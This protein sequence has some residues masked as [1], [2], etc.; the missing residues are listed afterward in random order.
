MTYLASRHQEFVAEATTLL[1]REIKITYRYRTATNGMAID[2][3]ESEAVLLS[4]SPLI[5]SIVPDYQLQIETYA[6]PPW[7]GAE[8]IWYGDA[9]IQARG[10][11]V[12]VGVI[13]TGINWDHPSFEDPAG[14]GYKH[15]NPF[16][17]YLGL[18][19]L[20][21]VNCN[22]KLVGVYDFVTD[23]PATE[24]V[25]EENT[26]GKDNHNHGSHTASTAAGNPV[27]VFVNG[28]INS[29]VSGVAPRA[30]IISYRV[31]Y[32]GEP[33][34]ADAAACDSSATLQAIGQAITDGVDVLNYSVGGA[35]R[36]PWTFGSVDRAFLNARNAGI[37]TATSAGNDG[38]NPGTVGSPANAPWVKAVGNAT[39]NTL[40]GSAIQNMTGGNTTPPGDI[41]GASLTGGTG[42]LVIVHAK[43]Y[44]SALCG[45]GPAESQPTCA[46][47]T[48]ASSPWGTEKVFNGEIVVC[49]R[50]TYGRVEKGKN[51]LLAGAGGY[52]LANTAASVAE[53]GDT[54][55]AD[56]H[57]LPGVHVEKDDGD[58]LRAWLDSGSGHGASLS[59]LMLA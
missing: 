39:H 25:V 21:E 17:G 31:C 26:N 46:G 6:G 53:L 50:G 22:D 20:E 18:C 36:D 54:I 47:N 43:D 3:S 24:D 51:V 48:G 16:G 44:G 28:A 45:E 9:G 4:R 56:D 57:C 13:D 11:G 41:V 34:S 35:P 38:P 55:V 5:R 30:N 29:Q 23:N 40:P 52:V 14:D 58:E 27:N 1:G 12:L 15:I 33:A 37:Y 42:K 32:Q 49:D 8:S 7:I 2:I 59:G 10:E 19:E